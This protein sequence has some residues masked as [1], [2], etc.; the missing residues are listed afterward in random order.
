MVLWTY[1][2]APD[3]GVFAFV[4]D[5]LGLLIYPCWVKPAS[6]TQSFITYKLPRR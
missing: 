5:T 4:D 6:F 2:V 1:G 3:G